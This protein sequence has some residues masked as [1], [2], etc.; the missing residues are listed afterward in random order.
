MVATAPSGRVLWRYSGGGAVL[1]PPL[2]L[3]SGRVAV[4]FASSRA[5]YSSVQVLSATGRL[6][7]G[8][9]VAMGRT[10][11][12][13]G[14]QGVLVVG[15]ARDGVGTVEALT[16]NGKPLWV[17]EHPRALAVSRWTAD[18]HIVVRDD[19]GDSLLVSSQGIPLSAS[20]ATDASLRTEMKATPPVV[21]L[22]T[23]F[24]AANL[25]ALPFGI[26]RRFNLET[27]S[28]RLRIGRTEL[29]G[30]AGRRLAA[31]YAD[32]SGA[33]R[34]T[35]L[36]VEGTAPKRPRL[37]LVVLGGAATA[38]GFEMTVDTREFADGPLPIL[39]IVRR[40]DGGFGFDLAGR[41]FSYDATTDK[42]VS[43]ALS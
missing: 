12:L 32:S 29:G 4:R 9:S 7:G 23:D 28:V 21:A 16:S 25:D 17:Y 24:A 15:G 38:A 3:D 30:Y 14:P 26:E 22:P 1:A 11:P 34:W 10:A 37:H 42:L 20:Q 35:V 40:F 13:V 2:A 39:R 33:R 8:A 41:R 36:A 5:G 31:L 43:E 6:L 18:G 19:G 27:Q